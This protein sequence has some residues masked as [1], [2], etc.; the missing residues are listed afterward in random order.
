ML[1]GLDCTGKGICRNFDPSLCTYMDRGEWSDEELTHQSGISNIRPNKRHLTLRVEGVWANMIQYSTS[2]PSL[3]IIAIKMKRMEETRRH[4]WRRRSIPGWRS[5]CH[6]E[7]ESE[8]GNI[9][10][11]RA[12]KHTGIV[13]DS[14]YWLSTSIINHPH[15]HRFRLCRTCCWS[16]DPDQDFLRDAYHAKECHKKSLSL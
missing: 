15:P 14:S 16:K 8:R 9:Y 6:L 4:R 13:F 5:V 2:G 1:P 7:R 12:I 3:I 11:N 10:S